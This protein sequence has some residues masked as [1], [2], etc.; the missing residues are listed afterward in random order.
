MGVGCLHHGE[1]L[2]LQAPAVNLLVQAMLAYYVFLFPRK[3]TCANI[4]LVFQAS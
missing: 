1:S 4:L 2:F 3:S